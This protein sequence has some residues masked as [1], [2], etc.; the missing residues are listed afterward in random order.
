MLVPRIFSIH[1]LRTAEGR[2]WQQGNPQ[3]SRS[4]Q[5]PGSVFC[6]SLSTNDLWTRSQYF[7]VLEQVHTLFKLI[8]ISLCVY[9][10]V[11]MCVKDESRK[12]ICKIQLSPF[13]RWIPDQSLVLGFSCRC[14]YPLSHLVASDS[15]FLI[16][17]IS[18]IIKMWMSWITVLY[19]NFI[20]PTDVKE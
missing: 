17:K 15:V 13:T 6:A 19:L 7:S 14:L 20:F 4:F 11:H 2:H 12:T 16:T 5:T 18:A 1:I 9:F 10:C 8:F 3:P